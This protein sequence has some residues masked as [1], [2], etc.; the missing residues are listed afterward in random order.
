MSKQPGALI[1]AKQFIFGSE[2]SLFRTPSLASEQLNSN[3]CG[4][5]KSGE[6]CMVIANRSDRLLVLTV[7]GQ[8]G[9]K[10]EDDFYEV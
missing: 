7:A 2:Q 8:I 1:K 5:L 6:M 10:H 9:W 3:R 4:V